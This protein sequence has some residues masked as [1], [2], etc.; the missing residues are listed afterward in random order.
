MTYTYREFHGFTQPIGE[1]TPTAGAA[2]KPKLGG[3]IVVLELLKPQ[4][5]SRLTKLLP[6]TAFLVL[7]CRGELVPEGNGGGGGGGG[8]D[9]SA[10][11]GSVEGKAFFDANVQ[12]LLGVARA[13]GACTAC[14]QGAS[15][16][17]GAVFGSGP[18]QNYTAIL[19]Y[20]GPMGAAIG[21]TPAT[22]SLY[23]R[24]DHS[25]NAFEANELEIIAEWIGIEAA[26]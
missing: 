15:A 24:G 26:N 19:S 16:I 13:K 4:P 6:L 10:N 17:G 25:G 22:S 21:A 7:G 3:S 9:A 20:T 2:K 11:V 23:S 18:A 1:C 14:H 5:M 8:A 12:A